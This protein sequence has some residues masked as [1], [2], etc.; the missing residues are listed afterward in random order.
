MINQQIIIV[1]FVVL[2]YNFPVYDDLKNFT[3]SETSYESGNS[4]ESIG[5]R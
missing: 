4:N 5:I 2:W 3:R 1:D